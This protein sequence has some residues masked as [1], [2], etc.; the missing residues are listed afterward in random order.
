[1]QI[2]MITADQL[3]YLNWA[4]TQPSLALVLDQLLKSYRR[5]SPSL[6]MKSEAWAI[7]NTLKMK[8]VI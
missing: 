6:L 8:A 5:S 3:K 1:M 7:I 2:S 4:S